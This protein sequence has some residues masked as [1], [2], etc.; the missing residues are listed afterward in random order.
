M[1]KATSP[2]TT[3]YDSTTASDQQPA[4]IVGAP[5]PLTSFVGREHEITAMRQLLG[6]TRLL[7]LT[8]AGGSGKTR[9]ALEVVGRESSAS[10]QDGVWVE[11]APV[12]DPEVLV[13]AVLSALGVREQ[14]G[15]QSPA[16]R[17]AD[18]IG[19]RSF[20]LV[21][22]NCEH[23]VDASAT[24]ADALLRRCPR[25][26]VIVTSREALGVTGETAWLI[27][28]LSLPGDDGDGS[29]AVDLFVE[30]ARAVLPSFALTAENRSAVAQICR[31]LDGL[32]LAVELAAARLR[33][34]TPEQITGRLD[35]RFRLLKTGNRAALPRHQTL[36]AVIDWSYD[37][38]AREEQ[39]LLARLAVF[40]G[41]FTLE[42]AEAVCTG[43]GI[44][45]EDVL[46]IVS[47]LV[48]KS[49][50]EM[51]EIGDTARYR[52]L[53]TVRQYGV[54]RLSESGELGARQCRH[55]EFF[56]ALAMEAEP[57]LTTPR[58]PQWVLKLEAD[59]DNMRQTLSWSR[60]A[61]AELH[62]RLVGMLHWFW[63]STGQWPEARQWL[64]SALTLPISNEPTRDRA[65]V[66]FSAGAIA[67]LQARPESALAH[68]VEAEQLAESLGE[69]RLLGYIRNYRGMSLTQT[70][71]VE[72][73]TPVRKALAWF[74]ESH[75]LYGLRLSFLLL[76]AV[77]Q[78]QG[79]LTKSVEAAEEG[80]RVARVFGLDRELAIALQ[81]LGMAVT[82]SGDMRRATALFRES[83]E[84]MR[85]DPQT[86]F[87]SRGLEM[88]ALCLIGQNAPVE[89]ARIYGAAQTLRESIGAKMWQLDKDQHEPIMAR[90]RRR[91]GE[92]EFQRAFDEGRLLTS[93]TVI[94]FALETT[95]GRDAG[96]GEEPSTNTAEY[97]VVR[98][99]ELA[100][101][102]A[103][104]VLA[105]GTLDIAVDGMSVPAKGWGYNKA[106]ELL[107]YLLWNQD[108]RS[109][110]QIGLALWPDASAA[111]VR[112]NFH[113]TLHHLRKALRRADWVKFERERY[114]IDAVGSIEFDAAQFQQH[115]TDA[116]RL[117]KRGNV[118]VDDLRA[119]LAL[120]RGHFM[121]GEHVGDWHLEIRD[122]LCRLHADGLETLGDALLEAGRFDDA[123]S[124]FERLVQQ[125]ELHEEGYRALMTCRAR[126]GDRMAAMREYRRLEAVLQRELGAQAD[127]ET[128]ELF[129]RLQRGESV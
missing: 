104:R 75:D 37:L 73:E 46:D 41:G 124:V 102:A 77:H 1:S 120:Y 106:R 29:E 12:R 14:T 123:A 110:D 24:L 128:A 33:V 19:E 74:R 31:R 121:N 59:L 114:R 26:R 84:S 125:E 98:P 34:L 64:K 67:C 8:G 49:L 107:L 27:P 86:L 25:L 80:V 97:Q 43:E 9:L 103:L 35:D 88:L 68:L 30:R 111:Q 94:E 38:L 58:R 6:T 83:L 117:A 20:L 109:R 3:A 55:A 81:S 54:D 44:A 57:N 100:P 21:L 127:R 78:I 62:M 45:P 11:L 122:R 16:I 53:E 91:A 112:N 118:P 15:A 39:R 90:A 70:S 65:A 129:R 115:V 32:P 76:S 71:S 92:A 63:F 126:V 119:A 105:L 69:Q 95:A 93:E 108:G 99:E 72:A 5:V 85:R 52:L 10:V 79:D 82:R 89:A 7:T 18:V 116:L 87:L 4:R 96:N 66:L 22:D 2:A 113:V 36:R 48:E 51:R 50:V 61:D 17:L 28:P 101:P 56:F 42:A 40:G 47:D 60:D 23:L 13:D